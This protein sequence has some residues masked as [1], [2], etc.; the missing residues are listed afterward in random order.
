MIKPI[1]QNIS[2][3]NNIGNRIGLTGGIGAGKSE[4]SARLKMLG[5][6]IIDADEAS[7]AVVQKG[8]KGIAAI[9]DY[10]GD[11]VVTPAGEL[12]RKALGAIVFENNEKRMAL[13]SIL[14]PLIN[15]YMLQK[16]REALLVHPDAVIIWDAALL[17]EAN[18]HILV[19]EVWLVTAPLEVRIERIMKRDGCGRDYAKSRIMSQLSDEAKREFAHRIV[20]NEGSIDELYSKVDALYKELGEE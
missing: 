9:K 19:K 2:A 8:G 14:H 10:F 16:E 6:V 17:I 1:E 15:E 12:D 11:G 7:K 5:A 20:N 13:N 4:V 18:M 3:N